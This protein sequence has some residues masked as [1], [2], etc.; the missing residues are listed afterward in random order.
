[1]RPAL[2][3]YSYKST[4]EFFDSLGLAVRREA[5]GRAY[6]A[7]SQAASVVSVLMNEAET[8]GVRIIT[9]SP[10]KSIEAKNGSFVLNGKYTADKLV[11][12]VQNRSAVKAHIISAVL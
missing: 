10:I 11:I 1:M 5:E 7:S 3:K 12:A 8:L 6:P 2:E 4:V 9:D